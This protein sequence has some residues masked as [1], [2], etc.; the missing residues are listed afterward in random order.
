M[1]KSKVRRRRMGGHQ[2]VQVCLRTCQVVFEVQLESGAV[3]APALPTIAAYDL[4]N[5]SKLTCFCSVYRAPNSRHGLSA[6]RPAAAEEH[7]RPR[8]PRCPRIAHHNHVLPPPL[9]TCACFCCDL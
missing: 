1:A 9:A 5:G 6:T 2:A 7:V 3:K 4:S 8:R